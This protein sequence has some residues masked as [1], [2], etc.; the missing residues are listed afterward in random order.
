MLMMLNV[1]DL[2]DLLEKA[3][4]PLWKTKADLGLKRCRGGGFFSGLQ[5]WQMW[6]MFF[7][8]G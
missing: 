2:C 6:E 1:F 5:V 4:L 3:W 7:W 8:S